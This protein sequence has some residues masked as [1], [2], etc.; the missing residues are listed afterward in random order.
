MRLQIEA[1]PW[2]EKLWMTGIS[3]KN[4]SVDG[5]DNG[6]IRRSL[7]VRKNPMSAR[8]RSIGS[9]EKGGRYDSR[10]SEAGKPAAPYW[11]SDT[12]GLII[13]SYRCPL[14]SME[15]SSR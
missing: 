4:K 10:R 15:P 2:K 7:S 12:T 3:A 9:T 8:K 5:G 14:S 11:P 13:R 1:F 6:D